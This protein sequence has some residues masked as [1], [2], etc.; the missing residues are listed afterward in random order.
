MGSFLVAAVLAWASVLQARIALQGGQV[1]NLEG[2]IQTLDTE[3]QNVVAS[4]KALNEARK[5][6]TSLHQLS[7]NRYL[8]ANLLNTL[9]QAHVDDVRIVKLR[10]SFDYTMTAA[11]KPKTNASTV[12]PGT[13]ATATEKI[14]VNIE[15]VD[16]CSNPG[17]R[18]KTYKETLAALP[19][20]VETF[21]DEG[22]EVRLTS[23][24]P[25]ELDSSGKPYVRFSLECPYPEIVR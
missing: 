16:F 15:A 21:K 7:T 25:P 20:F 3:Y 8:T 6:L 14:V 5:K 2:Q 10:T 9:Q 11:T 12:I 1:S 4:L 17:D 24:N 22:R 13:P 19:H 23:L 18:V